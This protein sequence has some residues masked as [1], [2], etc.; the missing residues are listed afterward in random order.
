[1]KMTWSALLRKLTFKNL[2]NGGKKIGAIVVLGLYIKIEH[3][4]N[5]YNTI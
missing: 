5:S 3:H 2:R 1:M 4:E